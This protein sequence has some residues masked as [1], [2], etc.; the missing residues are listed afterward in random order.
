MKLSCMWKETHDLAQVR[1]G[2]ACY[3]GSYGAM[4]DCEEAFRWLQKAMG[5]LNSAPAGQAKGE[6]DSHSFQ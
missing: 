6:Q 1:Y 3:N 4:R 2:L 5:K